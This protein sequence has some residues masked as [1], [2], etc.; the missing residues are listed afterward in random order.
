MLGR[1]LAAEFSL[2]L[3]RY[4]AGNSRLLPTAAGSKQGEF[5]SDSTESRRTALATASYSLQRDSLHGG[6]TPL[7]SIH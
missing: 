6:S 1:R 2:V 5:S 7:Q 4:V 3:E